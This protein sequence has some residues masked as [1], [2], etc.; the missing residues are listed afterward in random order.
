[1]YAL[2]TIPAGSKPVCNAIAGGVLPKSGFVS[3]WTN[4]KPGKFLA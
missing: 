4:A 3:P 1:M 2:L